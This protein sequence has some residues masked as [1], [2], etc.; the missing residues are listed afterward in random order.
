MKVNN[1]TSRA[2]KN[3]TNVWY[4]AYGSNMNRSVFEE[5]RK[6]KPIE[7]SPAILSNYSL[8]WEIPGLPWQEP[9]FASVQP[10]CSPSVDQQPPLTDTNQ[11]CDHVHGV[12]HLITKDQWQRVLETEGGA[13]H[14]EEDTLNNQQQQQQQQ[15]QEDKSTGYAVAT[16][17]LHLYDGRQLTTAKTLVAKAKTAA[18]FKGKAALPSQRYLKLLQEGAKQHGLSQEYVDFLH[19]LEPYSSSGWRRKIGGIISAAVVFSLLVPVLVPLRVWRQVRGAIGNMSI[20]RRGDG[21]GSG[22]VPAQTVGMVTNP[23]TRWWFQTVFAL[24]WKVH[25]VLSPVLTCGCTNNYNV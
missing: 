2:V 1:I 19:S 21:D 8:A 5:R 11:F 20:R 16:V 10:V 24:A 23:F 15:Q 17:H 14:N 18:L 4:F 6:I 7:S 9:A 22:N 25:D 12:A 13:E 3:D